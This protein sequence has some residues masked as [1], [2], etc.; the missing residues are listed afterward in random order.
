MNILRCP[1]SVRQEKPVSFLRKLETSPT[2]SDAQG[3][4]TVQETVMI[5]ALDTSARLATV[6][7][8]SLAEDATEQARDI[9]S[10]GII[11]AVFAMDRASRSALI[12][13][14]QRRNFIIDGKKDLKFKSTESFSRDIFRSF[15]KSFKISFSIP[16]FLKNRLTQLYQFDIIDISYFGLSKESLLLSNYQED[17]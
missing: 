3:V 10:T 17:F 7:A 4:T 9:R 16:L 15:R 5:T 2:T 11:P 12:A 6:K 8:T 1:S 13:T 14:V